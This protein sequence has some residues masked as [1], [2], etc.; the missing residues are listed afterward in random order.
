[1]SV[2]DRDT[3]ER[4]LNLLKKKQYSLFESQRDIAKL[5]KRAKMFVQG[6]IEKAAKHIESGKE[7]KRVM[8]RKYD[9]KV[10][11][12]WDK[13][14]INRVKVRFKV[15]MPAEDEELLLIISCKEE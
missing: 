7:I 6:I 4:I 2:H 12:E 15:T 1:M 8:L 5:E 11:Y 3:R 14:R 13:F 9:S 10:G